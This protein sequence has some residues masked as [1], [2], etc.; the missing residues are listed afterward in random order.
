MKFFALEGLDA[1]GKSSVVEGL[2]EFGYQVY[3]TPPEGMDKYRK[4]FDNS[5]INSRLVYY[6]S[7]VLVAGN[8]MKE[9]GGV[10]DRYLLTTIS[11]HELMGADRKL[12]EALMPVIRDIPKPDKTILLTAREDVR[13]DRLMKRGANGN[14]LANMK[15]NNDLLIGY[16]KW[17]KEL[18]HPLVEVDTSDLN[19]KEV[20]LKVKNEL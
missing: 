4:T 18:N 11:A 13:M 16:R 6:L 1:T 2:K 20:I 15:I 10:C 3:K 9:T 19:I 14:D 7:G 8:Q 5:D 17:A 12:I